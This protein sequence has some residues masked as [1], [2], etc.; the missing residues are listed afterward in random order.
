MKIEDYGTV[1]VPSQQTQNAWHIGLVV[2]GILLC[3]PAFLLGDYLSTEGS[4]WRIGAA[5]AVA[6]SILTFI[7]VITGILGAR[8]RL[9]TAMLL[10]QIFGTRGYRFF[11]LILSASAF[12]WF[13]IQLEIFGIT[14]QTAL[15]KTFSIS[16]NTSVW[17]GGALMI[18]TAGLGFKAIEKL[19]QIAVPFLLLL[20]MWTLFQAIAGGSGEIRMPTAAAPTPFGMLVSSLVGALAVGSIIMPDITR[21]AK[22]PRVAA[23]GAGLSIAIGFPLILFVSALL[24]GFGGESNFIDTLLGSHSLIVRSLAVGA[25][26]LATWTTNDNNLYSSALALNAIVPKIGKIWIT[27]TAGFLG[28]ALALHGIV[29]HL[30]SIM[31]YLG[32]IFTP[33]GGVLI[34]EFF[35]QRP[36]PATAFRADSW[37]AWGTGVSTALATHHQIFLLTQAPVL[38]GLL[39]ATFVHAVWGL[40]TRQVAARPEIDKR[41][42]DTPPASF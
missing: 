5:L 32:I 10:P 38:D 3:V 11:A 39:A 4:L 22:N 23:V 42:L 33:I 30:M 34:S 17:I 9:S 19:S 13:A 31:I 18:S 7:S 26:L 15:S 1:P 16:A 35:R 36:S 25:L 21:Y 28:M 27:L 20:M 8:K 2:W 12:G 29:E 41:Q 24:V 37:S 6:A 40:L 14:L